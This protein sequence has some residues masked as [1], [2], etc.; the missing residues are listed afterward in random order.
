M[1]ILSSIIEFERQ[2]HVPGD[3]CPDLPVP[4]TFAPISPYRGRLPRSPRTGDV[5]P[6]LPVPGTLLIPKDTDKI[7][8]FQPINPYSRSKPIHP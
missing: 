7:E 5:C 2:L 3:V 4:G 1:G 6:D 8:D